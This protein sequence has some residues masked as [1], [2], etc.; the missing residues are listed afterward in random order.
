MIYLL[1]GDN[2]PVCGSFR[3]DPTL[4]AANGSHESGVPD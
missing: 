3:L 2:D 1:R 4:R